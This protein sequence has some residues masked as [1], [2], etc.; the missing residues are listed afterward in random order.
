MLTMIHALVLPLWALL[1]PPMLFE[2]YVGNPELVLFALAGAAALSSSRSDD[3]RPKGRAG[4]VVLVSAAT[5]MLA[6]FYPFG[7]ATVAAGAAVFL[8]ASALQGLMEEHAV[9]FGKPA[10]KI[11]GVLLASVLLFQQ[12]LHREQLPLHPIQ[13][14]VARYL[15]ERGE[16]DAMLVTPYWDVGW[17]GKTRHSI[18]ADYQTAH[19]MTYLPALGPGLKKL[20]EEVFGFTLDGASGPPLGP[21][22]ERSPEAWQ[23]LAEAYGFRY[24]LAPAEIDLQLA[25]VL[26]S[27]PYDLYRVAP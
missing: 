11:A 3:S 15:A 19:L 2:R 4:W 5:L 22:P 16:A 21:W 7:T 20:H 12:W 26:E 10:L 14:E 27:H 24:L 13:V 25:P 6:I 8:G 23:S 18:I 9:R 1:L 17:L